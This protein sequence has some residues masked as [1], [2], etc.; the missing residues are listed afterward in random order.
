MIG[1]VEISDGII[2][3]DDGSSSPWCQALL[4]DIRKLPVAWPQAP[5]IWI[6]RSLRQQVAATMRGRLAH[7]SRT[8]AA[9]RGDTEAEIAH[10]LCRAAS[11][12]LLRTPVATDTEIQ[13]QGGVHGQAGAKLTQVIRQRVRKALAGKWGDLV[14][15][16]V[17]EQVAQQR[18]SSS[19]GMA[20]LSTGGRGPDGRLTGAAAQAATLKGRT[21]SLRGAVDVLVGGPPVPPGPAADA[22][23]KK[24][25]CVDEL[26][27]AE[28]VRLE[29]ALAL[30]AAI[31]VRKRLKPTLRLVGQHVGSLK[32]AAGPG[33]SGWRNSHIQCLYA[34]PDGPTCLA[35]WS[36]VWSR[37]VI[38]P[39][40][41]SLWT[42]SLARPFYKSDLQ[43]AIRPVLCSE[44]L[45][46]FSM[47]V[48]VRGSDSQLAHAC[49]ERQFG[50]GRSNGAFQAIGEVRAAAS[51]F[52]RDVLIGLD[53]ENAFGAVQWADALTAAVASAPKLAVAMAMAWQSHS[54]V[55]WMQDHHRSGWHSFSI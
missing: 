10:L 8:A 51:A 30:A 21:G 24:L 5:M 11:Q 32:P 44:A 40:L 2:A 6:P 46:K 38:Q 16:C 4:D 1:E 50:A 25:F 31:P 37:G 28:Q 29:N 55:V 26:A 22:A 47:G 17:E 45:F 3:E 27:A 48:T 41:A 9:E 54:M 19:T 12:L 18:P 52:P 20:S 35:E 14:S 7:A 13:R 34:D 33:P 36:G 49:G 43:E 23:V 39:W 42:G 53:I 15:E